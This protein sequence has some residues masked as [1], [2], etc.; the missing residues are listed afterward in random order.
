MKNKVEGH[1]GLY[2]DDDP[3]SGVITNRNDSERRSYHIAKQQAK[4][5][6][7]ARDE[8]SVVKEELAELSG[9]KE[10]LDELKAMVQQLL[11]KNVT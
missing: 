8:L 10:E 5:N 11:N 7:E 2:K 1:N 3:H 6:L 4:A 9:V